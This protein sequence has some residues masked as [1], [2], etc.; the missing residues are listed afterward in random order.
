[1]VPASGRNIAMVTTA[2]N[3]N[4]FGFDRFQVFLGHF[5]VNDRVPIGPALL[6]GLIVFPRPAPQLEFFDKIHF[7]R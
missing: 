1:M 7:R 5:I 3:G 4:H 2:L 6:G